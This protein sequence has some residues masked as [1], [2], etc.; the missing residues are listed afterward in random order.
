VGEG[1]PRT[2]NYANFHF[3]GFKMWPYDRK[4]S[5]KIAIFGINLP[6]RK[7]RGGPYRNLNIDSCTSRNLPLC[8]GTIIVLKISL[9]YSVSVITNFQI[10]KICIFGI[11]LSKKGIPPY[12]IFT[13]FG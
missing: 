12:A 6:L 8:N 5:P 13:K 7:N 2:H 11:N 3:C 1:V 9:L 4:K 10:A